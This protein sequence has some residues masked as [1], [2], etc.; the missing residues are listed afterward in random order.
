MH[1]PTPSDSGQTIPGISDIISLFIAT[2]PRSPIK[3][4]HMDDK[5]GERVK[6]TR[7]SYISN[8]KFV[9]RGPCQCLDHF[10]SIGVIGPTEAC[11]NPREE[12]HTI[13]FDG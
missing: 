6:G 1:S 11:E 5:V 3:S 2:P 7:G 10:E 13:Y 4:L 12:G 9:R 8:L